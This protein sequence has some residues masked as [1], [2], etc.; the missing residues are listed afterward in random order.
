MSLWGHLDWY[1]LTS[2][3]SRIYKTQREFIRFLP[4]PPKLL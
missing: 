4:S 2:F 1:L 3:V